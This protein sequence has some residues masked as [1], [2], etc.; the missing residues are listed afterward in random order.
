VSLRKLIPYS[1]Y[2]WC[3]P[4][5]VVEFGD[6]A[7]HIVSLAKSTKADLTVLGAQR[8]ATYFTHM[9]DGVVS[10]V[11]AESECPVM[12]VCTE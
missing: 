9:V 3:S 2:E 7:E 1:A 6:A 10:R 12:T 4:E 5:C 8:S 11:L